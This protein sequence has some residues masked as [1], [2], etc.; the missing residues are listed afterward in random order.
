VYSPVVSRIGIGYYL[1]K[2]EVELRDLSAIGTPVE[3]DDWVP[4][5]RSGA[6]VCDELLRSDRV[7]V[8]SYGA[9]PGAVTAAPGAWSPYPE[10]GAQCV[11]SQL[12]SF[13]VNDSAD[14]GLRTALLVRRRS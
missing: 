3:A 13:E 7:W 10:G 2:S 8:M 4:A 5:Q 6:D 12:S 9:E 14:F 1:Q 11:R